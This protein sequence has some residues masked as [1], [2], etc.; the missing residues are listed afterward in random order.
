MSFVLP[1]IGPGVIRMPPDNII[2]HFKQFDLMSAIHFLK[3]CIGSQVQ[4]TNTSLKSSLVRNSNSKQDVR[5][6]AFC[7]VTA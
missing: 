5:V 4:S 2:T 7:R 3:L 6:T 1:V